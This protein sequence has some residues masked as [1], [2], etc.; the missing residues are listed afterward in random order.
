MS[1]YEVRI[2]IETKETDDVQIA[3]KINHVYRFVQK[4]FPETKG[5]MNSPINVSLKILSDSELKKGYIKP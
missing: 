4:L 2:V 5:R 1:L 3:Q